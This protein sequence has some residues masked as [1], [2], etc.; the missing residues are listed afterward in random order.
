MRLN[1]TWY[2]CLLKQP[3]DLSRRPWSL[4]CICGLSQLKASVVTRTIS[5]RAADLSQALLGVHRKHACAQRFKKLMFSWVIKAKHRSEDRG[6]PLEA[7]CRQ[8]LGLGGSQRMDP[9]SS[10]GHGGDGRELEGDMHELLAHLRSCA[11]RARVA[12][13]ASAGEPHFIYTCISVG[14][15][16]LGLPFEFSS[17]K[18]SC[19]FRTKAALM[20]CVWHQKVL[21]RDFQQFMRKWC[22]ETS[23]F[24]L[25]MISK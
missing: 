4:P 14:I 15:W 17:Q 8:C 24:F 19:K 5:N 3:Q 11:S 10:F 25:K 16:F 23:N 1:Y 12:G 18:P 20:S 6:C 22:S 13:S 21:V 7:C 2:P 9:R